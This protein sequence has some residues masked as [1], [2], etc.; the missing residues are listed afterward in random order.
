MAFFQVRLCGDRIHVPTGNGSPPIIGFVT[1]RF[2]A[3]TSPD[4]VS[5]KAKSMVVREWTSGEY[6]GLNR[7]TGLQLRVEQVSSATLFT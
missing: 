3:A 2:A 5:E 1:T 7:G 4:R 6:A